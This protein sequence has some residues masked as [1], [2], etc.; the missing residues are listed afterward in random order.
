MIYRINHFHFCW[1]VIRREFIK[2][3]INK[4]LVISYELIKFLII[5]FLKYDMK[6]DDEVLN[7][8]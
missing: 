3:L 2:F 4:F 7:Y 6:I 8:Y 5:K 1:Q